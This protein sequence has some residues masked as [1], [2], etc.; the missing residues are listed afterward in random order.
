MPNISKDGFI[1]KDMI[2][3]CPNCGS[4]MFGNVRGGGWFL[5]TKYEAQNVAMQRWM[6]EKV[7]AGL[8]VASSRWVL[9]SIPPPSPAF[10]SRLLRANWE[11]GPDSFESIQPK[12]ESLRI[13][14]QLLSRKVG[15][16]WERSTRAKESPAR[17]L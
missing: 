3:K 10:L 13:S 9:D 2:P 5:H 11:N 6:Q 17:S 14:L 7:D 15:R 8:K 1:P 12:L 4:T 16:Y